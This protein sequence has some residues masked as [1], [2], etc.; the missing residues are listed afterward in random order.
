MQGEYPP[1]QSAYE[2]R[3][4]LDTERIRLDTERIRLD[5][6]KASIRRYRAH[7]SCAR[8]RKGRCRG[9]APARRPAPCRSHLCSLAS[10]SPAPHRLQCQ[11]LYV[12]TSK[13]SKLSTFCNSK[14]SKLSICGPAPCR[15]HLSLLISLFAY[16]SLCLS[17]SSYAERDLLSAGALEPRHTLVA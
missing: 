16:L 4:R 14:A 8:R 1:L 5:T 9:L 11:Y 7:T 2:E 13:A 15:S 3:I 12:C 10:P 17:L 6:C